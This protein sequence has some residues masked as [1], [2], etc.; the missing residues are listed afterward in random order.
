[1]KKIYL[2]IFVLAVLTAAL[3]GYKNFSR[4]GSAY[5]LQTGTAYQVSLAVTNE[6]SAWYLVPKDI[7]NL[8]ISVDVTTNTARIEYTTVGIADVDSTGHFFVWPSGDVTN[9]TVDAMVAPPTAIRIVSS[10]CVAY[11]FVRAQ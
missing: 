10:N 7:N 9:D 2:I 11:L 6:A 3:F 8:M 4:L 5:G 1:M